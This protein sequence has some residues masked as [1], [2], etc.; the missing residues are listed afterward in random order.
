M[1]VFNDAVS[2]L[3]SWELC[4]RHSA[5]MLL[6]RGSAWP[7]WG[8]LFHVGGR[9]P[10]P[11]SRYGRVNQALTRR[12][13]KKS[14]SFLWREK[15]HRWLSQLTLLQPPWT[16]M[17]RPP[18]AHGTIVRCGSWSSLAMAL[19]QRHWPP[20]LLLCDS[21]MSSVLHVPWW[22]QVCFCGHHRPVHWMVV[23]DRDPECSVL[24][25]WDISTVVGSHSSP[26]K[27]CG[28]HCFL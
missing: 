5:P 19:S 15:T 7:I 22:L 23:E 9:C 16:K 4:R 1:A 14:V 20:E 12:W 8:H 25:K 27:F 17:M 13:A 24:L 26:P 10:H 21:I 3:L 18:L 28:F 11:C 2:A 6:G